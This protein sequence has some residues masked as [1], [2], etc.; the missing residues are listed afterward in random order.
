MTAARRVPTYL[1]CCTGA[2]NR[3]LAFRVERASGGVSFHGA[4]NS[5][6]WVRREPMDRSPARSSTRSSSTH[7]DH[8]LTQTLASE[9]AS[10]DQLSPDGALAARA[11]AT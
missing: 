10:R 2:S 4:L 5:Y 9:G 3:D 1:C 6:A 7:P 11:A 8:P